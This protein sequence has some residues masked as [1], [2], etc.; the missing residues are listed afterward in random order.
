MRIAIAIT[1]AS[2]SIYARQLIECLSPMAEVSVVFTDNG[3]A[4]MEYEIGLA[5][6]GSVKIKEYSNSDFYSPMASGSGLV[7]AMVVVPCSMGMLARIA[8]GVSDDL[9][10]RAAD[11]MLKE[12]RPLIVVPRETP[13]NLIHLRN[14][15]SLAEAGAII[16]PAMPSFYSRPSTLD[17]ACRTVTDRVVKLLGFS[18]DSF[19]WGK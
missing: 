11:V 10:S 15:T 19:H 4:V 18:T 1:G 3:R 5:W 14:M 2:G 9:V 12:R 7:D 8:G 6:L 13:M 16:V 17:E